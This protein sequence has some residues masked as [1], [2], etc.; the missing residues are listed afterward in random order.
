MSDV[1]EIHP[2]NPQP[3]LVDRA[4]EILRRGG[5]IAYP[6]DSCYALGTAAANKVGLERIC[7]IR[8]LRPD[9]RFTLLCRDLAEA[10][11]FCVFDTPV[12]R[13]LK[14]ATPGPYAF[15]LQASRE[16]PKRL[17]DAKRKTIGLRIPGHPIPL[18]LLDALGA[19]M[20]TSSLILPGEEAALTD[21]EE[22][23]GRV[24]HRLDLILDGGF[25]S[26]EPTTVVDLTGAEP[27][28]VRVGKG[29]PAPFR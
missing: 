3:R 29:D 18:A 27:V 8:G 23:E 12:Y 1:L 21:A 10:G 6:T 20:M 14:A 15:L 2:V 11:V 5:V 17:L 4:A 7:R 16:A 9:H 22:I 13:M 26:P 25:C 28:V 24:G 19:P